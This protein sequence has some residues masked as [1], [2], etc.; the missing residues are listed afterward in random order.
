MSIML[1][2]LLSGGVPIPTAAVPPPA[3]IIQDASKD[4]GR[5]APPPTE[6]PPSTGIAVGKDGS[7]PD[8]FSASDYPSE[9][10]RNGEQG[11]VVVKLNVG[12][13][14]RV[15]GCTV[16][17]SSGSVSLDEATC[18]IMTRRAR[19]RPAH[20]AKGNAVPD[21]YTQKVNWAMPPDPTPI[22]ERRDFLTLR[23]DPTGKVTGCSTARMNHAPV[24]LPDGHCRSLQWLADTAARY[25]PGIRDGQYGAVTLDELTSFPTSGLPQWEAVGTDPVL[26][27]DD[28][29]RIEID[30]SGAVTNCELLGHAG[31]APQL[32]DCKNLTSEKYEPFSPT[33]PPRN[34]VGFIQVIVSA[35]RK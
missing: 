11:L 27:S 26:V 22:T 25:A 15:S 19:F 24:E 17:Q 28:R 5:P 18:K 7:L 12:V 31:L 10:I 16:E 1:L 23:I 20:D 30:S 14:G 33:V 35:V 32:L 9:A 34:W 6:A 2:A 8:L 29:A 4:Y 21:T 3:L 13:D